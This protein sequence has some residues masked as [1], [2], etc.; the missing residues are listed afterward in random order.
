LNNIFFSQLA[1]IAN[2]HLDA[3]LDDVT[4]F[5]Q[6][7]MCLRV[8][9]DFSASTISK[10]SRNLAFT[11]VGGDFNLDGHCEPVYEILEY[12]MLRAGFADMWESF[13]GGENGSTFDDLD[14]SP[15][16]LDYLWMNPA[17][18]HALVTVSEAKL[19]RADPQLRA[20]IQHAR[21]RGE[22]DRAV[23]LEK[24]MDGKNR[25]KRVT[26]HGAVLAEFTFG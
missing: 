9:R 11:I 4:R 15:Q 17:P 7:D 23:G 13:R 1:V 18:E 21:D 3:G 12:R 6:L 14:A 24:M 25:F 5:D 22:T 2:T 16:R 20:E 19:W 10:T 8:V 26:H